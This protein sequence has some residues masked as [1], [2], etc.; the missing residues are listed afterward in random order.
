MTEA[1]TQEKDRPGAAVLFDEDQRKGGML[2]ITLAGDI[3]HHRAGE[4]REWMD[5]LICARRPRKLAL[6]MSGIEFMDS[7]GLGLIMGRYSLLGRLGGELIIVKPSAATRRMLAL[8]AM[9]RLVRI[10]D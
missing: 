6:D 2:C 3:D 1:R 7:S 10:E 9:E 4:L 8:A 5:E